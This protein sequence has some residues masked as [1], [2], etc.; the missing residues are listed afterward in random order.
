ME[1]GRKIV[2]QRKA[3][4]LSQSQLAEQ[5]S[6]TR[7]T[8]SRWESNAAKPDV[9]SLG[10][11][12]RI[13][14]IRSDYFFAE[15]SSK[16]Q[17]PEYQKEELAK[18]KRQVL[19]LSISL[20]LLILAALA[21]VIYGAIVSQ[22]GLIAGASVSLALFL[23]IALWTFSFARNIF[24]SNRFM[25]TGD[26]EAFVAYILKRYRHARGSGKE[27][28][29][30]VLAS[31]YLDLDE[32]AEA[33]KY[34]SEIQNPLIK[35]LASSTL[36][37]LLLD[38]GKYA[39]AKALYL[40]YAPRHRTGHSRFETHLVSALDG[41]F[42]ALDGEEVSLLERDDYQTIYDSPLG[43]KLWASAPWKKEK[44]EGA[45]IAEEQSALITK[46][47][48]ASANVYDAMAGQ[49]ERK[50]Q[51]WLNFVFALSI[52]VFLSCFLIAVL[53]FSR[54]DPHP[55]R[56]M[57]VMAFGAL[58]GLADMIFAI[59]AHQ[60]ESKDHTLFAVI[61]GTILLVLGILLSLTSLA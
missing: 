29:A 61:G 10:K 21:L 37:L 32:L 41:L 4:H 25:Q 34:A 23:L 7:Q 51:S 44:R 17:M 35:E 14:G 3:H 50:L 47:L 57:W 13:F 2:E 15:D 52:A 5:L 42:R 8:L 19:I 54:N 46:R 28:Y 60:K 12:A 31:A 11:M 36:I 58:G 48:E 26:E 53:T 30:N 56:R 9:D 16:H 38:E 49:G 43:K 59:Y 20:V 24:A 33:R 45:S 22:V 18:Q 1:Y 6:I 55:L 40:V 27:N 39:E